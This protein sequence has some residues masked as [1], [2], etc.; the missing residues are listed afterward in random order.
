MRRI[1]VDKARGKRT[2]K[3]G[4]GKQRVSLERADGSG[5]NHA[6]GTDLF[7]DF[8]ALDKAL[9]ELESQPD[10]KRKCTI[11]ELRFFVGLT[12]EQ[13]AE[14]LGLSTATVKRDWEYTRAWLRRAM[15][16]E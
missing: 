14:V 16:K 4:H 9:N 11:V 1:L 15:T 6:A 7:E 3:R 12:L 10:Q 8:E 2:R 13:T 5:R